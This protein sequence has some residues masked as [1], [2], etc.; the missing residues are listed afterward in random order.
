M[1]FNINEFRSKISSRKFDGLSGSNKF[2]VGIETPTFLL[3]PA[4]PTTEELSFFCDTS[5]IPGKTINT[6]DY[7][8]YGYGEVVKMPVS[9]NH[10]TLTLSFF[11]D[12]NYV[13]MHFFQK[14]LEYIVESSD[15][16]SPIDISTQNRAFREIAYKEDY[17]KIITLKGFSQNGNKTEVVEYKFY[18]AYPTQIGASQ[19]GWEINDQIIKI[20]VEFTYDYYVMSRTGVDGLGQ[21]K[22]N[23]SLFTRLAQIATIAGVINTIRRPRSLQ[24]LINLSVTASTISRTLRL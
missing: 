13:I 6:I 16:I 18:N 21:V 14:W 20:P 23:I 17:Q 12:S 11:C 4:F 5:N 8:P 3:N 19:Y 2:Y 9:R 7:K 22:G 10:D 1:A 24:D 15:I